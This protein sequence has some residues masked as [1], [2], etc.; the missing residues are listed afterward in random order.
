[1]PYRNM[2]IEEMARHLGMDARELRKL[3]DKGRMPGMLVGSEWRFNRAQ[4]LDW[5][6]REMHSLEE[7]HIRNLERAMA[8]RSQAD[9]LSALIPHEGIDL[10]LRAASKSSV[11]RKLVAL[12]E[13]T[14]LVYDRDTLIDALEEREKIISTG[15]PNG[16]ALPHPS[17]LLPYAT[18]EPLVCIARVP[19][20]VPFGAP[21]GGMT[22]LFVLICSHEER[23]H[24]RTLARLALMI[25]GGFADA[26]RQSDSGASALQ[27]AIT[28][29]RRSLPAE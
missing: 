23:Q 9:F 21:D 4:M 15:L 24:L 11:L 27:A 3:A 17:R 18:A 19:A 7:R 12:A 6:Q 20:G 16:I 13:R 25:N 22:D 5:L 2:S 14:G 8:D 10:T 28:V 26:L 29:E 1:M